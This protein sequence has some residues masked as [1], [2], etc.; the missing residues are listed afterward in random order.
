MNI[1]F[2]PHLL[3]EKESEILVLNCM[4]NRASI[5]YREVLQYLTLQSVHYG[6]WGSLLSFSIRELKLLWKQF[7][8]SFKLL[9]PTVK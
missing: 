8:L 2:Y 3:H 9:Q 4:V 5:C 1:S 7:C 6:R